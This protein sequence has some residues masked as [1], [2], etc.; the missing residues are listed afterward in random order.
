MKKLLIIAGICTSVAL[1]SCSGTNQHGEGT[2]SADNAND[3]TY[4]TDTVIRST[5]TTSTGV[6][7]S[8][9]GGTD[10]TDTANTQQ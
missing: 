6:D 2:D 9:N 4:N 7:N 5:D 1:A 10:V 8:G 3:T